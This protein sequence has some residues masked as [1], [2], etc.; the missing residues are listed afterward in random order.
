MRC[1]V[2]GATIPVNTNKKLK[3]DIRRTKQGHH[4]VHDTQPDNE[5]STA[6]FVGTMK[7][8]NSSMAT[9]TTPHASRFKEFGSDHRLQD[10]EDDKQV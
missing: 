4:K 7:M 8:S 1:L 3:Y 10:A 9:L 2:S 5:M 6:V